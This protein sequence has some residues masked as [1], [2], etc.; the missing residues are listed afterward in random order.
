MSR[1]SLVRTISCVMRLSRSEIAVA[2][3][4]GS[5]AVSSASPSSRDFTV[6]QRSV[7]ARR[8]RSS[9]VSPMRAAATCRACD[10]VRAAVSCSAT[11]S[12]AVS[13]SEMT[14]ASALPLRIASATMALTLAI[15]R[16]CPEVIE[17]SANAART[18][19]RCACSARASAKA[20]SMDPL[21]MCPA[22]ANSATME[23]RIASRWNGF[24]DTSA[25]WRAICS[26]RSSAASASRAAICRL[27]SVH[28]S[29]T[30]RRSSSS[31]SRSVCGVML[32]V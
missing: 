31:R 4:S 12:T 16:T 32:P 11:T 21:E 10:R 17:P 30:R 3:H 29:S 14:S 9:T 23:R 24:A 2:T 13:N 6:T 27:L 7:A 20:K 25:S 1:S 28:A 19:G 22:A 26:I 8:C 15:S 18:A 5:T